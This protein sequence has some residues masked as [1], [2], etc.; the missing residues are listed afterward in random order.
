VAWAVAAGSHAES[1]G[2]ELAELR[3]HWTL[4]KTNA[5][6]VGFSEYGRAVG[7]SEATIRTY[8][9]AR[10]VRTAHP[11][12]TATE[13]TRRAMMGEETTSAVKAIVEAEG[14][15]IDHN[16]RCGARIRLRTCEANARSRACANP[17]MSVG[18][19]AKCVASRHAPPPLPEED[20]GKAESTISTYM[21][22][23]AAA[24]GSTP[25][26]MPRRTPHG[27]NDE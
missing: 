8:A 21:L 19:R 10:G 18:E 22:P 15:T 7:K 11:E 16:A 12:M 3:W 14:V 26:D 27:W 23:L 4:D 1:A 9:N 25:S 6:K 13:A 5:D 24:R 17:T 2:S 20:V